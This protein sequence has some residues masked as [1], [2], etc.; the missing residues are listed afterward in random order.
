[1]PYPP[2]PPQAWVNPGD[3]PPPPPVMF[4]EVERPPYPDIDSPWV[5]VWVFL[6]VR[7]PPRYPRPMAP[8]VLPD[9]TVSRPVTASAS[10]PPLVPSQD[11]GRR[12]PPAAMVRSL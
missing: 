12:L 2:P 5:P 3:L 9:A 6:V 4:R 10:T 7:P 8:I 1:M 11:A